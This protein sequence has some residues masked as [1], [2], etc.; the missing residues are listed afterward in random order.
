MTTGPLLAGT[1]GVAAVGL[2]PVRAVCAPPTEEMQQ[3]IVV[4]ATRQ[5]DAALTARVMAALQQNP[6]IFSD[7]VSVTTANGV[8]RITGVVRDLSDLLAI[9]QIA[10]RSAGKGRV[11]D[12]I[13]YIPI[14]D[15]GN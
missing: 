1:L 13:E 6:Y 9:L 3:E 4:T 2:W 11:V 12:E 5:S 14:D 7:H 15:D 10:R 8:V